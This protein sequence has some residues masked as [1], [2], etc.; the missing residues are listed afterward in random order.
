MNAN[1]MTCLLV[2][3]SRV[4][5]L[6]GFLLFTFIGAYAQ[7]KQLSPTVNIVKIGLVDHSKIRSSYHAFVKAKENLARQHVSNSNAYTTSL[8]EVQKKEERE[9]KED[10]SR[11]G[12]NQE[13]IKQDYTAQKVA[14]LKSYK[15]QQEVL[16]LQ[17]INLTKEYEQNILTVIGSVASEKGLTDVKPLFKEDKEQMGE[18]ITDLIIAKLNKN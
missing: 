9:L 1:V 12:N 5:F 13:K 2:G 18:D 7:K 17:R 14:L 3:V 6:S 16:N 15:T 8:D 11:G 4:V 10:L